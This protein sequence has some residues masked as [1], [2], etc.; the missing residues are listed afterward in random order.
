MRGNAVGLILLCH[1][2]T[3]AAS[4]HCEQQSARLRGILSGTWK[5][6]IRALLGGFKHDSL[7]SLGGIDGLQDSR[8][9]RDTI[10]LN[11]GG[12]KWGAT[13]SKTA[14]HRANNRHNQTGL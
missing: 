6:H 5:V 4:V 10:L 11:I 9:F 1:I 14:L 8:V 3:A 2:S 13:Q 7:K 12:V